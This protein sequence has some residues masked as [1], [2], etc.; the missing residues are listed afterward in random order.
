MAKQNDVQVARSQAKGA[1][2]P[3]D[4]PVRLSTSRNGGWVIWTVV[5]DW[6]DCEG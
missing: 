5:P 3:T 2:Q 6:V 4:V 1:I